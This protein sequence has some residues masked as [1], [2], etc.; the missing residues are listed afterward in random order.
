MKYLRNLLFVALLSVVWA[1]PISCSWMDKTVAQIE[2]LDQ[3]KLDKLNA[4]VEMGTRYG[5]TYAI[6]KDNRSSLV[7]GLIADAIATAIQADKYEPVEIN[8]VID[9]TLADYGPGV[10]Y[11]THLGLDLA[12]VKYR[13]FYE[14]N[15]DSYKNEHHIFASFL[16]AIGN[17]LRSAVSQSRNSEILSSPLPGDNPMGQLTAADL[18]L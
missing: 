8:R 1:L 13:E 3:S 4:V 2:R 14:L 15:V 18:K 10:S 5:T 17:G 6:S 7:F 12:L 9:E 16:S 11:V